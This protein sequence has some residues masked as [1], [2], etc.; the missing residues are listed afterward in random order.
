MSAAQSNSSKVSVI[1][2]AALTLLKSKGDQ[3]LT[4]RQVANSAGMTLSNLQYYFKNKDALLIGMADHYFE[5]CS[6]LLLAYE[7]EQGRVEDAQAL[8]A[9]I[10]FHLEHT[11]ELSDMCRTFRELWAIETRN[12]TIAEHMRAYYQRL[13]GQLQHLIEP[14]LPEQQG[15]RAVCLLLPYFEGYSLTGR[16]LPLDSEV[17]SAQLTEMAMTLRDK[18]SDS[19]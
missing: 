17:L 11:R 9:L 4:M 8:Q 14:L 6:Q 1:L 13:A 3:G 12:D 16:S 5:Q 19:V 2:T 7:Q 10:R 18:P 15:V